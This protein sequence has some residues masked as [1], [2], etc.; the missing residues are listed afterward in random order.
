MPVFDTPQPVPMVI[1]VVAGD[2]RITASERADTIIEVRPSDPSHDPDVRAAEQTRVE[3][4]AAGLLVKGPRQRSRSLVS[5]VG[6]VDLTIELP[7]G[8]TIRADAAIGAVRAAGPLGE[9]RI[10]TS[11]GDIDVEQAGPADLTCGAGAITADRVTGHAEISSGA[12]RIRIGEVDGTAAVKNANGDIWVGQVTG[13]LRMRTANG[14]LTVGRADAGV[15][16]STATGA[17]RAGDIRRGTVSLKTGFGEIEIGIREGT[18]AR[19]D[20]STGFGR[21]HN[22]LTAADSP[23]EA[24]DRAEVRARTSYGDIRIRRP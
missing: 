17:I 15:T 23:G 5:K 7:S 22:D 21:V 19:L 3:E 16:A 18:A 6:A 13:D 2:I 8:S 9:C 12:G 24:A 11:A 20:V 4:T 10:K 14:D 1:D